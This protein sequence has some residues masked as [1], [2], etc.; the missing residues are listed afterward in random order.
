MPDKGAPTSCIA[1]PIASDPRSIATNP[2]LL[3]NSIT[4]CLASA[5]A[6]NTLLFVDPQGHAYPSAACGLPLPV[7][8]GISLDLASPINSGITSRTTAS[9]PFETSTI[10]LTGIAALST[11]VFQVLTDVD[12]RAGVEAPLEVA[13]RIAIEV[14][15]TNPF[16]ASAQG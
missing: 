3:T 5:A 14:A 15:I 1:P 7:G 9:R 13:L 6:A 12:T 11:T 8:Q 4:S 16:G 2:V 10:R